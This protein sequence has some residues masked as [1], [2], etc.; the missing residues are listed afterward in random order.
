MTNEEHLALMDKLTLYALGELPGPEAV[1]VREHLESCGTC[2]REY[3]E[4]SEGMV[5][6][7]LTASGPAA[8][9]RSRERLLAAAGLLEAKRPVRSEAADM[10]RDL[11]E[12]VPLYA[13]MRRP[14]WSFA[15]PFAAALLALFAIL[16]WVNNSNLRNNLEAARGKLGD[17]QAQLT[18]A[19]LIADALTSPL[20]QKVSLSLV[21]G[22]QKKVP[23]AHTMYLRNRKAIVL[24]AS[25]LAPL[26]TGKAY[27][28]WLLP[29]SG[30]AP[31][32]AGT[33]A[34]DA[35]GSAVMTHTEMTQA[36]EAKGFAI[37]VENAAGSEKPTSPILLVG[38]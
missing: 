23:G 9:A 10:P 24:I 21:G 32:A 11:E 3:A 15:S 22:G 26:P 4:V 2:R 6:L 29:A 7:A 33:F 18:Q 38:S 13:P 12:N 28:L 36:P 14:W 27:E 16:L 20:V 17:T 1:Q 37:T 5:L 25:N 35:K 30:A 19:Q 34:P 8:P 31:L